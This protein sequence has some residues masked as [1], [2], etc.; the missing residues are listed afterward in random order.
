MLQCASMYFRYPHIVSLGLITIF[1]LCLYPTLSALVAS[2]HHLS[3]TYHRS[4]MPILHFLLIL[5]KWYVSAVSA[6]QA[7]AITLSFANIYSYNRNEN[8]L[9]SCNVYIFIV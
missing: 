4:T 8:L 7:L 3:Y 5:T 9:F 1:N 6:T 2:P